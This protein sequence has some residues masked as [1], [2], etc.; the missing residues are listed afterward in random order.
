MNLHCKYIRIS[1]VRGF[2]CGFCLFGLYTCTRTTCTI[3]RKITRS[4]FTNCV[5]TAYLD[6]Q[7]DFLVR[8]NGSRCLPYLDHLPYCFPLVHSIQWFGSVQ[9]SSNHGNE[10]WEPIRDVNQVSWHRPFSLQNLA[11]NKPYSMHSS[12]PQG[13]LP[14]TKREVVSPGMNLTSIVCKRYS[15]IVHLKFFLK[16]FD[17]TWIKSSWYE[18]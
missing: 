8:G 9:G 13:I 12:L 3:L 10:S 1:V 14:P 5:C 15:Q 7:V 17:D 18:K 16:I 11:V 4:V 6:F 2:F